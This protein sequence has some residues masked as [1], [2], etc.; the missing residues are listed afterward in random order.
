MLEISLVI[1][2]GAFLL[3]VLFSIPFLLQIWKAMKK[4]T[5]SLEILNRSLPGILKNLEETS[6][7][8]NRST[9]MVSAQVEALVLCVQKFQGILTVLANVE[10]ILRG[11]LKH[12]VVRSLSTLI[13]TARGVQTFWRVLRAPEESRSRRE[14]ALPEERR[15]PGI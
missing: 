4:V 3:I 14:S 2:C 8:I 1:I 6:A 11:R 12:P 13:A 9:L 7:N 5:Q 10:S 15:G